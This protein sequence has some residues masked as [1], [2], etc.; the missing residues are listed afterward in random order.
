MLKVKWNWT[1]LISSRFRVQFRFLFFVSVHFIFVS[2]LKL[3][4]EWPK[5][6]LQCGAVHL[7]NGRTVSRVEGTE[8][9]KRMRWYV[10]NWLHLI[11]FVSIEW[12]D[13]I[14]RRPDDVTPA[15]PPYTFFVMCDSFLPR[16]IFQHHPCVP[17]R[18]RHQQ[19]QR[20]QKMKT[21]STLC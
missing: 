21:T 17:N 13:S 1:S 14:G 19:R 12:I 4:N 5:V 2:L 6:G 7:Q 8:E 9:T 3:W 11:S 15:R 10:V 20:R 16:C 18:Q